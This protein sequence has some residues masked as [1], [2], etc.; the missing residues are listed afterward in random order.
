MCVCV[1]HFSLF[2]LWCEHPRK[3]S[4]KLLS[5]VQ[6][7]GVN[8]LSVSEIQRDITPLLVGGQIGVSKERAMQVP[9]FSS[10]E[11][12]EKDPL[13]FHLQTVICAGDKEALRYWVKWLATIFQKR[14]KTGACMVLVGTVRLHTNSARSWEPAIIPFQ[15]LTR[16]RCCVTI[17]CLF[18][19]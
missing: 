5:G 12:L 18:I 16:A 8:P 1:Q 11:E 13:F 14:K 9:G 6:R 10:R 4:I 7:E 3:Q 19:L 2:K 15:M 17:A